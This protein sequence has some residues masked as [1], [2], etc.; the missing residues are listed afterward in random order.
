MWGLERVNRPLLEHLAEQYQTCGI[1]FVPLVI[2][3][4]SL[5][6][7]VKVLL[8]RREMPGKIIES[9]DI[10]NRVKTIYDAL[11]MPRAKEELPDDTSE[12]NGPIYVLL[13]DDSLISHAEVE[14]DTLWTSPDSNKERD[15]VQLVVEVVLRPF[16]VNTFNLGFAGG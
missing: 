3:Q 11:K 15:D 2:E 12:Y 14:T 6:C 5:Y 10:D 9:G 7:Y 1:S 13:Q 16:N 4:F 8:L